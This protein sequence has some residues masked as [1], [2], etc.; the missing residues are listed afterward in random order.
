MSK[1]NLP[2]VLHIEDNP[3]IS[4]IV[5][6]ILSNIAD[7]T[8]VTSLE[9]ARETIAEKAFDLAIIDLVLPDGS[10]LDMVSELKTAQPSIA[11]IIHSAHEIAETLHG[12]D[13]VLSK[14]YTLH[15]DLRE[16]VLDLTGRSKI[17]ADG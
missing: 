16:L 3:D 17:A 13:A 8:H 4:M 14:M 10:G 1:S 12:V 5:A 15:D 11:I 7:I 9:Q 2:E 6:K